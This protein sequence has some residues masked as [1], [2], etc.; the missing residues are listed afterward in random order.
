[1]LKTGLKSLAVILIGFTAFKC[2]DPFIPK[3]D[4]NKTWLVVDALITDENRSYVV[5]LSNS[6]QEKDASTVW[7][8]DASVSVT[9]EEGNSTLLTAF[10][11]GIYKT[12]SLTF[13]GEVGKSY[14]LHILT[15]NGNEYA[16]DTCTIL[17]VPGIDTIYFGKDVQLSDNQSMARQGLSVYL[18][19]KAGIDDK[20]FLR[21]EYEETWKFGVTLPKL[22]EY[23]NDTTINQIPPAYVKEFCWKSARSAEILTGAVLPGESGI[24]KKQPVI[25]ISPEL[26]DRISLRYS[27]LIKQY[28]VSQREYDYWNNLKQVNE[29]NG[30]IF[31]SQPF[32]VVSNIKNINDPSEQ[33]LGYFQVSAVEQ[34]RKY[35]DYNETLP[36]NLPLY[37]SGCKRIAKS[38]ADYPVPPFTQ[39]VTFNQIYEMFMSNPIYSF[40]EPVFDGS[41]K[42]SKL[43]FTTVECADCEKTGTSSKPDFWTDN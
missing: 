18:D 34:K 43:V 17:P 28:S 24:L 5:T 23:I 12:D 31:G 29:T 25:F 8:S 37:H 14:R 15:S 13:R 27:I 36:L 30:D 7:V 32:A 3:L 21:W 41:G 9:D 4:G 16:S 11:N 10:G 38:P 26:S 22:Y 6:K 2:I 39:P 20:Y 42:L 19:T 40:V 35:I 1:M 33:V